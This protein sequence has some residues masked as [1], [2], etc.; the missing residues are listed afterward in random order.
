MG[1][2]PDKRLPER[3]AKVR[4]D[5]EK[6]SLTQWDG[7]N[8]PLATVKGMANA[9]MKLSKL[10]FQL[11]GQPLNVPEAVLKRELGEALDEYDRVL[12]N[13]GLRRGMV[14]KGWENQSEEMAV[15]G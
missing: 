12:A 11:L 6:A 14:V 15:W 10:G 4:I 3:A 13:H 9:Q 2:K 7:L 5:G 1:K 8:E